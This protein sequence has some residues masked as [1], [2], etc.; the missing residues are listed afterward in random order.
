MVPDV[1]S[2]ISKNDHTCSLN[3]R[4]FHLSKP[5]RREEAPLLL[6]LVIGVIAVCLVSGVVM[7]STD[8]VWIACGASLVAIA[9]F[10][11][12]WRRRPASSPVIDAAS[13]P[14]AEP[15]SVAGQPSDE[16]V[17]DADQ[18]TTGD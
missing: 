14:P 4:G 3:H 7:D 8:L 1:Y 10:G 11:T 12:V 6:Y 2:I 15:A 13:G 17:S 16:S 5:P 18:G 9:A